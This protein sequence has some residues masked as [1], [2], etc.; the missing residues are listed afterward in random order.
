MGELVLQ[1]SVKSRYAEISEKGS[2]PAGSMLAPPGVGNGFVHG[3]VDVEISKK[4]MFLIW[5]Q[6]IE[7]VFGGASCMLRSI[8]CTPLEI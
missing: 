5:I 8:V 3:A 1:L 7:L 2:T 4:V 6:R